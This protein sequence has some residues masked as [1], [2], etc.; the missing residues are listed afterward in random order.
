MQKQSASASIGSGLCN[1]RGACG[2][3]TGKEPGLL[4]G[5]NLDGAPCLFICQKM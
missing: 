4:S 2:G 3:S 1:A 5:V